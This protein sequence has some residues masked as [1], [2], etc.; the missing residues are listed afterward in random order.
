MMEF[1]TISIHDSG[2]TTGILYSETPLTLDEKIDVI[3]PINH[4]TFHGTTPVDY[5]GRGHGTS[6]VK[7][8]F[9]YNCCIEEITED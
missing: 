9:I 5:I 2:I 8:G 1:L 7:N 4:K 3:D 6:A